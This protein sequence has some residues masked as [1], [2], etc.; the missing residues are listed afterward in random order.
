MP[1]IKIASNVFAGGSRLSDG[2][3]AD[4]LRAIAQFQAKTATAAVADLTDNSA[5]AAANGTIEA[6]PLLTASPLTGDTCPTK[7]E[8]DNA[9]GTVRDALTEIAA[10]IVL[11]YAVVPA[12]ANAPANSIGGATADGTI[13]AVTKTFTGATSARAQ[14]AGTN[15]LITAY[16]LAIAELARDVNTLCVATGV[17]PL[18]VTALPTLTT[19]DNTYSALTVDSGTAAADG[20]TAMTLAEGAASFAAMAAAVKEMATKLIAITG[21][22]L[23]TLGVIAVS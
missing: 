20:T 18:V 11:V 13:A 21:P 19:F 15:T 7:T 12:L 3:L 23:A 17:T 2:T 5:G 6:I 8:I 22:S 9:F 1:A 4:A 10:S 16:R 14:K